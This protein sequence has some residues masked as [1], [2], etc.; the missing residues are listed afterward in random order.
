MNKVISVTLGIIVALLT[1]TM[2]AAIAVN[3]A[4]VYMR[5]AEK[6]GNIWA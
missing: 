3:K 1:I 4:G 6:G 5:E 2:S